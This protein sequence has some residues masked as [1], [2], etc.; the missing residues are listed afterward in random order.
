MALFGMT[1]RQWHK[2][3]PKKEGNVRDYAGITQLVCL[4]NLESLNAEFIRKGILLSDRLREL[5]NIAITQMKSLLNN[6]SLKRL[7]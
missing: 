6:P 3:N 2:K 1:A 7:K 4:A 5:N